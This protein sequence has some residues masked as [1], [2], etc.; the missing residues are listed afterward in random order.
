MLM[1]VFGAG[2]SYDSVPS[3]PPGMSNAELKAYRLPLANQLFDDRELFTDAMRKF[4]ACQPIVPYLQIREDGVSV[5]GRLEGL[6][7][8]ADQYPER[9]RQLAAIRYYLHFTIWECQDRWTEKVIRPLGD[10]TNYKTFLDQ[11]RHHRKPGEGTCLVTFNYDTLLERTLESF[12]VQIR[13]IRDYITDETYKII[14]VHG[15]QNWARIVAA[16]IELAGRSPWEIASELINRAAEIKISPVYRIIDQRP[17]NQS[18]GQAVFPALAIPLERKQDFECPA[19]HIDTLR[20]CIASTTKL[21]IIGW[22]ATDQPFLQLLEEGLNANV[23]V[24]IVGGTRDGGDEI[25]ENLQKARISGDMITAENDTF[26][27]FTVHREVEKFL[28]N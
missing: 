28:K 2:A 4:P 1:V 25:R 19:E 12:G 8:E 6:Q 21:V 24:L 7:A 10:V 15:S 3:R 27:A 23:R 18:D 16:S 5:E 17:I 14:K 11:L 20:Q 13:D 9:N 26:T 22:R